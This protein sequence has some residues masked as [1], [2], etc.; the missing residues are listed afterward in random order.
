MCGTSSDP[1]SSRWSSTSAPPGRAAASF[2]PPGIPGRAWCTC[3]SMSCS[4]RRPI[5]MGGSA[6]ESPGATT[7]RPIPR[8]GV[9][10]LSPR[11]RPGG[12][13]VA[14]RR[15]IAE[16]PS[17]ES[18]VA[19]HQVPCDGL[20]RG[21]A[22]VDDQWLHYTL[23]APGGGSGSEDTTLATPEGRLAADVETVEADFERS[24]CPRP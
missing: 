11:G 9:R 17:R 12:W 10:R 14:V 21:L 19:K 18:P 5:T 20:A 6:P 4:M 8:C 16:Y 3:R 15:E 23:A 24:G 7:G 2:G 1:G 22:D 13:R